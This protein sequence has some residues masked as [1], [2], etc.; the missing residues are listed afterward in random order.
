VFHARDGGR[1]HS[2]L[3]RMCRL[4]STSKKMRRRKGRHRQYQAL[5]CCLSRMEPFRAQM[6]LVDRV[7]IL[8]PPFILSTSAPGICLKTSTSPSIIT[9]SILV[10]NLPLLVHQPPQSHAHQCSRDASD[11]SLPALQ[12]EH[13]GTLRD[14]LLLR[15]KLRMAG[16][17]AVDTEANKC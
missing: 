17:I 2:F 13:T 11:P 7:E 1:L 4:S 12:A 3:F 10:F 15:Q 5:T 9:L 16:I 14:R 6:L 8:H